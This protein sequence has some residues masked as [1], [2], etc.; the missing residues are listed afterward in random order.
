MKTLWVKE[1]LLITSNLSFS[2]SVFLPFGWNF[3]Y[4]HQT[5]NCCLQTLSVWESPKFVVWERVNKWNNSW[6]HLEKEEMLG[7]RIFSFPHHAFCSFHTKWVIFDVLSATARLIGTSLPFC[8]L[9]NSNSVNSFP[10][11]KLLTLPNWKN[12]RTTIFNLITMAGSS[13]SR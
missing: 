5:W 8:C 7:T 2:H 6:K 1:K 11:N 13:P 12:L 10:N 4:F 9:S 3:S